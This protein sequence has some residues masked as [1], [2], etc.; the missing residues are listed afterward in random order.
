MPIQRSTQQFKDFLFRI[1]SEKGI[2]I[3]TTEFE[4]HLMEELNIFSHVSLNHYKKLFHKLK[5]IIPRGNYIL[6]NNNLWGEGPKR[7]EEML[8]GSNQEED[9]TEEIEIEEGVTDLLSA[10]PKVKK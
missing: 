3:P 4:I 5:Y 8:K 2:K 7:T 6:I 9:P 1:Y 10:K